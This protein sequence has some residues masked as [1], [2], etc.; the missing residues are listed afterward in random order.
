MTIPWKFPIPG[1]PPTST[2]VAA[3]SP[4]TAIAFP[5]G[6]SS[7]ASSANRGLQGPPGLDGEDGEQGPPGPPGATGPTGPMGPPGPP[8]LDGQD[9]ADGDPGPPGA[10]GADG[11]AGPA[12]PAGSG[13][14][15]PPGLD[16]DD[17]D[18]GPPGPMG[19]AGPAGVTGAQ[20]PIGNVVI[21]M[22]R[23]FLAPIPR[24]GG[25]FFVEPTGGFTQKQIGAPV[26][27][28]M[29]PGDKD[30]DGSPVGGEP[31]DD[32]AEFDHVLAVARVL[33]KRRMR[34]TW[35]SPRPV[36]GTFQFNY[37]IGVT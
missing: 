37:V 4:T 34:V 13:G 21:G 1:Q 24:R 6:S 32:E 17:G 19:P 16:G 30:Y 14:I 18:W 27:I 15:G 9:G 11:A 7:G 36:K 8:G 3:T 2:T 28:T 22:C 10:R 23:A 33:D 25:K 12:G 31:V 26:V 29:A 35:F 5:M 20:G